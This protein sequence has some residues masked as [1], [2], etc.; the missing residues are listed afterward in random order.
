MLR[1]LPNFYV[2]L[3]IYALWPWFRDGQ[4]LP[5][6]WRFFTFTQN[7]ALMPGTSFS[8]AWS[9]C[10][11]EQFYLVLPALALLLRPGRRMWAVL[12]AIVIAGLAARASIWRELVDGAANPGRNYFQFIYYS[13]L[14]RLDELVAGVALALLKNYHA[15]AW[16][17]LTAHGNLALGAGVS[18][19]VGVC[20]FFLDDRLAFGITVAGYPLLGLACALLLIAALSERSLLR[21][22]AIPG[23]QSLAL[24]SYAIYL[25]H[26]QV[27]ILGGKLLAERGIAPDSLAAIALLM[28]A[29]VL[30][31]WLMY[32][33]VETP[34]MRLRE[35]YFPLSGVDHHRLGGARVQEGQNSA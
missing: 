12:A 32:L 24:W 25:T 9:L 26:K 35:R 4:E 29:S 16:R 5:P 7:I 2:M 13:S 18:L 8:H 14:C 34:F 33:L 30:S 20:W 1:T 6:L 27:A 21:A 28:G 10:I 3:A 15:G 19:L 17:R 22:L 31:G 23:A 11:E